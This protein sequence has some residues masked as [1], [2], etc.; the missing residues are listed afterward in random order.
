MPPSARTTAAHSSTKSTVGRNTLQ[1]C[2]SSS[3][4]SGP[5]K[6]PPRSAF[7]PG[8]SRA[9][10]SWPVSGSVV[11]VCWEMRGV[12]MARGTP[13]PRFATRV[14]YPLLSYSGSTSDCLSHCGLSGL[15]NRL[16]PA[17]QVSRRRLDQSH[18]ISFNHHRPSDARPLR[19]PPRDDARDANAP[20]TKSTYARSAADKPSACDPPEAVCEAS[21]RDKMGYARAAPPDAF[22]LRSRAPDA[23]RM[24][25]PRRC[26]LLLRR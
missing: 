12:S 8:A 7:G 9:T 22:P 19:K 6:I 1:P 5:P 14:L 26:P 17:R 25:D 20:S 15:A 21:S 18:P 24:P 23:R 4:C 13:I 2:P 3:H 10:G 11:D 16:I